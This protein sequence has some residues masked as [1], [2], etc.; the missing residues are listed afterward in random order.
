MRA[1]AR[2]PPIWGI[3]SPLFRSRSLPSASKG[4]GWWRGRYRFLAVGFFLLKGRGLEPGE[5]ASGG[6]VT[7]SRAARR[8]G[9]VPTGRLGGG[10]DWDDG[11]VV[12]GAGFARDVMSVWR[13]PVTMSRAARRDGFV[14]TG[15][16]DSGLGLGFARYSIL[17]LWDWW[18]AISH[19]GSG[20]A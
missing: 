11:L 20:A 6:P 9:F 5:A 16:R 10:L 18:S 2:V 17:N 1:P 14:P 3:D 13:K 8:D 4:R 7:M 19:T 15:R 12:F